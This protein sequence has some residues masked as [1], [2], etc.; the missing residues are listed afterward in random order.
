MP[1]LIVDL[2]MTGTESDFHDIIEIGAILVDNNWNKIS[3]YESLVYP[4]NPETFSRYSEEIHGISLFDLEDAPSAYDVLE[5]FE[6]WIKKSLK[7][8]DNEQLYNVVL[9][10][11]S[12][13]NDINFLK[14]KYR[15]LNLNWPFSNKMIDLM[16]ISF[17]MYRVLD[18]NKIARPKS[19]SLKSVA[20]MFQFSRE[21]NTHSAIEDAELT[22]SC[23][24]EYIKLIDKLSINK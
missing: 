10:G 13:I 21:E 14:F 22:Y 20:D 19:M 18:N 1:Y 7:L 8:K 6:K 2:E 3:E 24:K 15:E 17:A 11:Q 9:C 16:S 12:V 23:M 4:D 5:D